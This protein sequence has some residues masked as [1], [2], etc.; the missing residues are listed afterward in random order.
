ME[1]GLFMAN[2]FSH[3]ITVMYTLVLHR[4][5]PYAGAVLRYRTSTI[6]STQVRA[7]RSGQVA[8]AARL[9]SP[10]APP[11]VIGGTDLFCILRR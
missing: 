10:P 2:G 11:A 6:N 8:R 5:V 7:R 1:S 4:R 3:L 9:G